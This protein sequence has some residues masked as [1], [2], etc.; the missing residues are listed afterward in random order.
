M[1]Q[2]EIRAFF[3]RHPR[4]HVQ[5]A[6]RDDGSPA[7][8]WGDT[9]V[10]VRDESGAVRKMPFATIVTK[11]YAGFDV[12]SQLDRDGAFR[13]NLDVGRETFAA[14]FGFP[15]KE[16]D[17]HRDAFDFAARDRCFPHPVY[18][19]QGWVSIVAPTSASTAQT[20]SLMTHALDRALARA[21]TT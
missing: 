17:Q 19:P 16:L 5:V 8:A 6:A 11:D 9:F 13:L 3:A 2:D 15:P 20:E 12:E 4:V 1:T 10:F 18:G 7:I 21:T 14:L